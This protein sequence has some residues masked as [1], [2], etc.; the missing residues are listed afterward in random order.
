MKN[1]PAV[2][3]FVFIFIACFLS[4]CGII[5]IRNPLPEKYGDTAQISG[6]PRAKFWADETPKFYGSIMRQSREALLQEF[7][8]IFGKEHTHLALSGGGAKG[9]FGAGLMVGGLVDDE[10]YLY[11]TGRRKPPRSGLST[12]AS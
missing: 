12:L 5:P 7:P 1:K 4:S 6:I 8:G 11:I 2:I 3:L 10:G 9:A